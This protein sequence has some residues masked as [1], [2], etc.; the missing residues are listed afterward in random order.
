MSLPTLK[1]ANSVECFFSKA[2]LEFVSN[3]DFRY[4]LVV[5]KG[6]GIQISFFEDGMDGCLLEI[7]WD[8]TGG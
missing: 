4:R 2:R 7:K 3:L 6:E 1:R 8:N 5:L